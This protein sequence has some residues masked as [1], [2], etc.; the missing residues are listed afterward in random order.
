MSQLCSVGIIEDVIVLHVDK[1]NNHCHT[2]TLP[3]ELQHT[4]KFD[5]WAANLK[6]NENVIVEYHQ[7]G[8]EEPLAAARVTE[9]P[10]HAS[11]APSCPICQGAGQK[12]RLPKFGKLSVPLL[13]TKIVDPMD[14]ISPSRLSEAILASTTT[15]VSLGACPP[16]RTRVYRR[17]R[18]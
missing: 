6:C 15:N 11:S 13:I 16:R 1:A 12:L 7:A 9:D 8:W 5:T 10:F 17:F 14:R 3:P 4:D 2:F 18:P